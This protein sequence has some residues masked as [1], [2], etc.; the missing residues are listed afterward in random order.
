MATRRDFLRTGVLAGG[1]LSLGLGRTHLGAAPVPSSPAHA[2]SLSQSP[3]S[4]DIL[5]LG[6]TNLTGPHNVRYALERGHNLT[7]FTRGRTKPG[8]FQNAFEHVEHLIG[9]RENDLE[10]LRGRSWDA[11]ID[12]SGMNENWT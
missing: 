11:V 3:R 7:I 8:L 6:G 5:I 1:A 12:A 2:V 10:A 4:L 9:D